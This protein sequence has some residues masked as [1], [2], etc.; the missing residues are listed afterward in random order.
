[1]SPIDRVVVVVVVVD[2]DDDENEETRVLK[3]SRS[4]LLLLCGCCC[5]CLMFLYVVVFLAGSFFSD[6]PPSSSFFP[7]EKRST[8]LTIITI[9]TR[10][11][12]LLFPLF[13]ERER[14]RER[15]I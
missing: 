10:Q 4:R 8:F 15:K 7:R 2:V 3:R 13:G 12:L 5:L 14:K 1:M 6:A 11:H 9:S